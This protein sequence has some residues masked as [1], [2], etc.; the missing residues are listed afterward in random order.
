MNTSR[1]PILHILLLLI[2]CY[3]AFFYRLGSRAL[4]D[5]DEGRYAES[6]RE[7]LVRGDILTP[8][9]NEEPRLEKPI[10]IY[11]LIALSYKVFGVNEFS[12]RF[13]SAVAAT[14]VVLVIY[15]LCRAVLLPLIGLLAG[16]ILALS[17]H[18]LIIARISNTD[19]TLCFFITSALASFIT[20]YQFRR[21]T[22]LWLFY[23]SLALATLTKG[24]VGFVVPLLVVVVFLATRGE[25][26]FFRQ[27]KLL[28]G[29]LLIL[30]I[31]AP[32]YILIALTHKGIL[33]YYLVE[34]GILRFFST[35]HQHSEPIYYY[36]MVLMVSFFPWSVFM[37]KVFLAQVIGGLKKLSRNSPV[38]FYFF[39]W[40]TVVLVFFSLSGSKLATYIL[41]MVPALAVCVGLWFG[42]NFFNVEFSEKDRYRS[43]VKTIKVML[44]LI[45][46][47]GVVSLIAGSVALIH[48]GVRVYKVIIAIVGLLIF[49]I[50]SLYAYKLFSRGLNPFYS[51][52][53]LFSGWVVLLILILPSTDEILSRRRS[54]KFLCEKTIPLMDAD[55]R[56][57]M[58]RK[59]IPSSAIFYLKRRIDEIEKRRETI[60]KLK[61]EPDIFVII[62]S[63]DV[64]E[65]LEGTENVRLI[66]K[67]RKYAIITNKK[68]VR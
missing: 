12:A 33:R 38:Q 62:D 22:Y 26:R 17:P 42:A 16:I 35:H 59:R 8:W 31:N 27:L 45:S 7:M 11:W 50:S 6:A 55:D 20:F 30:L 43:S 36:P 49:V 44:I 40:Y 14:G 4:T 68:S 66:A 23:I 9:L 57:Y 47:A 60:S 10:L 24:Y 64:D 52:L 32:W 19:M 61:E 21:P 65:Y 56:V 5:P 58:S 18:H 54:T 63:D 67:G 53:L 2:V 51:I 25:M 39:I 15:F 28:K 3:F 48:N 1:I 29:V 41:P 34:E 13:P 37:P 46:V